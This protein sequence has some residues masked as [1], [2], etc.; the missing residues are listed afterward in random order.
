MLPLFLTAI[1]HEQKPLLLLLAIISWAKGI[2]EPVYAILVK[3]VLS[4]PL[5]FLFELICLLSRI[6]Y[7]QYNA[8]VL[9]AEQAWS[10]IGQGPLAWQNMRQKN[11]GTISKSA[12][13]IQALTA[14]HP[15][16]ATG[17][18]SGCCASFS[19]L[20]S[21]LLILIH[22]IGTG[23]KGGETLGGE[24]AGEKTTVSL[25]SCVLSHL[26]CTHVP[27]TPWPICTGFY[28]PWTHS[29]RQLESTAVSSIHLWQEKKKKSQL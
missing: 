28:C 12:K 5:V 1:P 3:T 13:L 6:Y 11:Q 19:A 18:A 2:S 10:Q 26:L 14:H 9:T 21:P 24:A 8:I 7:L 23:P 17:A 22:G 25:K 27:S 15:L 16:S 20:K 4:L 29:W